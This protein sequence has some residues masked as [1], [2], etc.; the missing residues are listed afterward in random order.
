MHKIF[1]KKKT[2]D[3]TDTQQRTIRC[4]FCGDMLTRPGTVSTHKCWE[5]DRVDMIMKLKSWE[6]LYRGQRNKVNLKEMGQTTDTRR[7]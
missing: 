5:T 7:Y 1:R 6:T 2:G 4:P 3:S